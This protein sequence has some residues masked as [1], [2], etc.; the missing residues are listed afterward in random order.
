[1]KKG[2]KIPNKN[3]NYYTKYKSFQVTISKQ[4][5]MLRKPKTSRKIDRIYLFSRLKKTKQRQMFYSG[6]AYCIYRVT[7]KG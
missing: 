4:G 6:Y 2:D 3:D 5:L 7:H 1:M